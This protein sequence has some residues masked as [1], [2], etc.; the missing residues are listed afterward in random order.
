VGI[1]RELEEYLNFEIV[2]LAE[3][4]LPCEGKRFFI[5]SNENNFKVYNVER[6]QLEITIYIPDLVHLR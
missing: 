2:K 1:L 6:V 4:R 5:L 3:W